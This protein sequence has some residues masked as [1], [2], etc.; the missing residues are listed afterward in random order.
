MLL[1]QSCSCWSCRYS[2]C[3]GHGGPLAVAAAA[4]DKVETKDLI[5]GRQRAA[6]LQFTGINGAFMDINKM[7]NREGI[8]WTCDL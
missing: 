5:S 6:Y 8:Q 1:M 3:S 7:M 2:I 4:V